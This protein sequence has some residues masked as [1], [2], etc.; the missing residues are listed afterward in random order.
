MEPKTEIQHVVPKDNKWGVRAENSEQPSKV[1][2]LKMD[3]ISYA[4]DLTEN[5]E[6]GKV[7]IHRP[8]GTFQQV[9]VTADT[10][11]LLAILTA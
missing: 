11:A 3:A 6:G 2:D 10:S 9:H 1:F 5:H 8:D 4:F 7:V